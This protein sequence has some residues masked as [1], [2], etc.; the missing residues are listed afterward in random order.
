MS[1]RADCRA[2]R[3]FSRLNVLKNRTNRSAKSRE[4]SRRTPFCPRRDAENTIGVAD[5]HCAAAP[6]FDIRPGFAPGSRCSDKRQR[7]LDKTVENLAN[8]HGEN[9]YTETNLPLESL[10]FPS[11]RLYV[12]FG[13]QV[14]IRAFQARQ[15]FSVLCGGSHLSLSLPFVVVGVEEK[16][17]FSCRFLLFLVL[18]LFPL[19]LIHTRVQ[20][21]RFAGHAVHLVHPL[22][23]LS[24]SRVDRPDPICCPRVALA[25]GL[26]SWQQ[27]RR[28]Q[29]Q[30]AHLW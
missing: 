7:G 26:S 15:T 2:D 5:F 8:Q 6:P 22:I 18:F 17:L 21:R 13:C 27:R 12:S 10:Q 9:W 11:Q 29:N 23:T 4:G 20:A 25:V 3:D 30:G 28:H 14:I 1:A 24:A 19:F 16:P